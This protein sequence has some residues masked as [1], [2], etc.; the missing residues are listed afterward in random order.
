M[1]HPHGGPEALWFCLAVRRESDAAPTMVRLV[2]ANIDNLLGGH[3]H[4]NMRPVTRAAGAD[5]ERLPPPHVSRLADG[6]VELIWDC[7]LD[8]ASLEIAL[9][10]P[11]GLPDVARLCAETNNA[12]H[13]DTIGT[14]QGGRLLVRLANDY[15]A[16]GGTRPGVYVV[17]RQHAGETP[18]SWVLDGF[19]RR[20]AAL[21]ANAPLI[22]AIP[23]SNIDGIEQGDYGKDNFPYDLNRAWGVPPMRHETL[24]LQRDMRRWAARCR[25][26]LVL[27]FHAPGGT[28]ADGMYVFVVPAQHVPELHARQIAFAK[29]WA[30]HLTDTLVARNSVRQADYPS[31]WETPNLTHGAW[32]ALGVPGV[33]FETPYALRQNGTVLYTRE[34]YQH[35]GAC[36]ADAVVAWVRTSAAS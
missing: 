31:R 21:G 17:A 6:R 19:L 25:P 11:Y 34:E 18:G 35:T 15:G 9:C 23:L 13:Y 12:W 14:S 36:T 20:M 29:M 1:A 3:A 30:E 27:D 22:W 28:E 5:W 7:R 24:V 26:M 10:Y 8:A 33:S 32:Q 4:A 16:E 2:L